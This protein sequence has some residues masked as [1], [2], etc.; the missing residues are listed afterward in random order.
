MTEGTI[1]PKPLKQAARNEE[2]GL[3]DEES[4]DEELV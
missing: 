1:E 3:L 4:A 2:V